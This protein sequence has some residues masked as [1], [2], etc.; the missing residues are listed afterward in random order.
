MKLVLF[1]SLIAV[2][3]AAPRAGVVVPVAAGPVPAP[4]YDGPIMAPVFEVPI[5]PTPVPA[6]D[7][8]LLCAHNGMLRKVDVSAACAG[9]IIPHPAI[10]APAA[11]AAPVVPSPSNPSPLVQI[12]LNINQEASAAITPTPVQVVDAAPIPVEPVQVVEVAP[13]PVQVAESAPVPSE[14]INVGDPILPVPV[15]PLPAD[16]N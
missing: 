15:V 12:I 11:P 1:A 7:G 8:P 3:V 4:A 10:A 13:T 14:P 2:A 9:V 5:K 6:V 16:F